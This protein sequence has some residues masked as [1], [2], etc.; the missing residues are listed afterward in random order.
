[1]AG[2]RWDVSP[3]TDYLLDTNLLIAE[4]NFALLPKP[5]SGGDR[6][7]TSALCYAELLEG[8]YANDPDIVATAVIQYATAY[9]VLGEGI[10]FG[11]HEVNSYRALCAAITASGRRITRSRR[12]DIMIAATAHAN[13][14]TLATRNIRD[15]ESLKS[16]VPIIE[17]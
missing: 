10:P 4:P 9:Q 17:L 16:L 12:I 5:S 15:F 14:M 2:K 6:F 1:M 11:Q 3:L 7:F 13:N 8:E